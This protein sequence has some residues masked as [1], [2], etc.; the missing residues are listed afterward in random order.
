M[1]QTTRRFVKGRHSL[2]GAPLFDM[3]LLG[4]LPDDHPTPENNGILAQ[5][6][7]VDPARAQ[8]LAA[9]VQELIARNGAFFAWI[10]A[11]PEHGA[12][13]VNDPVAAIKQALPDLPKDFFDDWGGK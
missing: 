10:E 1:T 3:I 11:T 13:F 7:Q 4:A 8:R 5:V 6:A 9:R 12:L 2:E